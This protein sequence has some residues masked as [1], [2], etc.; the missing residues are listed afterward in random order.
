MSRLEIIDKK[1]FKIRIFLSIF[2]IKE[3]KLLSN[4]LYFN[5]KYAIIDLCSF[6]M[7]LFVHK[8]LCGLIL[9]SK[10]FSKT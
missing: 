7:V 4:K 6:D 1:M 2:S 5:A 9:L 8:N 3:N 10:S